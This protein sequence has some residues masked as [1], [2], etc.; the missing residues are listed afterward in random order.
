MAVTP[1]EVRKVAE[2][3]RLALEPEEV[4]RLT[5]DLSRILEHVDALSEAETGGEGVQPDAPAVIPD[6]DAPGH[7]PLARPPA[8]FAPA[9]EDGYFTVP[10]LASHS[11]AGAD[12]EPSAP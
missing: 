9:F 4:D 2:L 3:A 8:A 7:D 12:P 5:A 11:D 10:R 6:S 1:E